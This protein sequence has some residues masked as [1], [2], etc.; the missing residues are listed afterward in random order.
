M[1]LPLNPVPV[2][3]L[4]G[5]AQQVHEWFV[6]NSERLERF[7]PPDSDPIPTNRIEIATAALQSAIQRDVVTADLDIIQRELSEERIATFKSEVFSVSL[8][9]NHIEQI[10]QRS[11]SYDHLRSDSEIK[12]E[13]YVIAK[14]INR[15]FIAETPE[16]ARNGYAQITGD[17]W[18]RA[19]LDGI[20]HQLCEAMRDAPLNEAPMNT[21]ET[22][23]R[24]MDQ[25]ISDLDPRTTCSW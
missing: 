13:E 25:A 8:P 17:Q 7:L 12:T 11:D 18:G 14:L 1:E 4:Q 10:F 19:I 16:G 2:L 24:A 6:N 9:P 3:D 23:L 21:P 20:I 15:G 5:Y 22:L